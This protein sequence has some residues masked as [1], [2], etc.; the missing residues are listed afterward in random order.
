MKHPHVT[1]APLHIPALSQV[2]RVELVTAPTQGASSL[3]Y[4]DDAD[5]QLATDMLT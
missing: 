3:L 5:T 1:L 4:D 2:R